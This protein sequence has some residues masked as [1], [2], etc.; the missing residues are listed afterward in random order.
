[1]NLEQPIKKIIA[2]IK[3]IDL[4]SLNFTE[5]SNF[6]EEINLSSFEIVV[7]VD[8]LE[9]A[10]NIEFGI[11]SDDFDSLKSWKTLLLNIEHKISSKVE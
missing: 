6:M 9:K 4:D 3:K 7:F 10:F 5:N 1:M 2:E 11:Q 8:K